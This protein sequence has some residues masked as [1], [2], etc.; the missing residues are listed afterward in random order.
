MQ[1]EFFEE[2][3][4]TELGKNGKSRDFK[5]RGTFKKTESKSW[6]VK[7]MKYTVWKAFFDYEKEG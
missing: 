5:V 7:E 2:Y 6:R 1:Q 4:I 3:Q